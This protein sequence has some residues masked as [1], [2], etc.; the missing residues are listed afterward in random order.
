MHGEIGRR[1]CYRAQGPLKGVLLSLLLH[2]L[3]HLVYRAALVD[4]V[5]TMLLERLQQPHFSM[6]ELAFCR[7]LTD[8]LPLDHDETFQAYSTF[9]TN[10]KPQE[11]YE[12]LLVKAS[13]LRTKANQVYE[14]REP[15]ETTLVSSVVPP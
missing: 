14:A 8:A 5:E 1:R 7:L 9:T 2:T 6:Y 11:Q 10:F 15:F 3:S 12:L 13:K 4:L